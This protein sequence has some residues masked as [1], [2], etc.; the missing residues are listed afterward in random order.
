MSEPLLRLESIDTYYGDSHIL[1]S[2]SLTVARGETVALLGRNGVGK[3]TTLKSIVGW[4]PPRAGRIVPQ[5]GLRHGQQPRGRVRCAGLMLGFRRCDGADTP[6]GEVR[7][8]LRR[9]FEEGSRGWQEIGR[10]HV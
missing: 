5:S 6:P 10:A 4:V 1:R 7:G 9:A 3:T 2:L 8:Q